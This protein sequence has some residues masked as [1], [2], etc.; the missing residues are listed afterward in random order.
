[1]HMENGSTNGNITL[2]SFGYFADFKQIIH[3][4]PYLQLSLLPCAY[5]FIRKYTNTAYL[6]LDMYKSI[7]NIHI[8]TGSADMDTY[9]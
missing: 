9:V 7:Y 6:C 1:M 5:K 8:N 2:K 3:T 4:A